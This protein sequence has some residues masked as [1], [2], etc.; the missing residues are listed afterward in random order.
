MKPNKYFAAVQKKHL[1]NLAP[2]LQSGRIWKASKGEDI[3]SFFSFSLLG[4]SLL[5]FGFCTTHQV[6]SQSW[7]T[8][9]GTA[10]FEF[11]RSIEHGR[12]AGLVGAITSLAEGPDAIG[13]N[14]AGIAL[15]KSSPQAALSGR[16][17]FAG[18]A[19]G[20][21]AYTMDCFAGGRCGF[22]AGYVNYGTIEEIDENGNA[23]NNEMLPYSV[24][25]SF[26]WANEI[27]E[28]VKVGV[29]LRA[30]AEYL[31]YPGAK[32]ALGLGGEAGILYQ[33]K[34]KSLGFGASISNLGRKMTPHYGGESELGWMP[35]LI[36]GGMHYYP[37]GRRLRVILHAELPWHTEPLITLGG[38]FLHSKYLHFRA[39][40]RM[41]LSDLKHYSRFVLGENQPVSSGNELKAS[42]GVTVDLDKYKVDFAS[43]YWRSLGFGHVITLRLEI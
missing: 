20:N 32:T 30:A 4:V 10:E 37:R 1:L 22:G 23:R 39:A 6:F 42:A 19:T 26:V 2:I 34:I 25:P 36:R 28:R 21:L 15:D 38:E 29:S 35:A 3:P 41:N 13:Y 17:L 43:Q 16:Y 33:P 9:P 12:A 14:P 8:G 11:I 24:T 7:T 31:N 27:R 18:V 5:L 40:T